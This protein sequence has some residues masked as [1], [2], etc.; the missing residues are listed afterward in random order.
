MLFE[1]ENYKKIKCEIFSS[2][3]YVKGLLKY[4][5]FENEGI[6]KDE[7]INRGKPENVE[8]WALHAKNW[9]KYAKKSTY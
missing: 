5:K 6:L 1:E 3:P 4:F 2:N 9:E 8:I 7:T